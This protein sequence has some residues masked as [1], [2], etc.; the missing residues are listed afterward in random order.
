MDINDA[1]DI[2][3]GPPVSEREKEIGVALWYAI[4]KTTSHTVSECPNYITQA[5]HTY[6]A[7]IRAEYGATAEAVK[8]RLVKAAG[9]ADA[10]RIFVKGD[11]ELTYSEMVKRFK[12]VLA[13]WDS[14]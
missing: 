13:E 8:A 7:E 1:A 2:L 9:L 12:A 4:S 10:A 3:Y 6:A 14:K 5:L 11:D